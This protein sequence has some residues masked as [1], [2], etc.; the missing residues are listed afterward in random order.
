MNMNK[1]VELVNRIIS[2]PCIVEAINDGHFT[3]SEARTEFT[4]QLINMDVRH[5]LMQVE[6]FSLS[7]HDEISKYDKE[8]VHFVQFLDDDGI[9][10]TTAY[11]IGDDETYAYEHFVYNDWYG[12][13]DNNTEID[14]YPC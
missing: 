10:T 11:N 8:L 3:I 4:D 14:S 6:E 9:R 7:L 5:G 13:A 1:I 12:Y 2:E